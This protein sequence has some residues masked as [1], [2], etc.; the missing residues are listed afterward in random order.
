MGD[1]GVDGLVVVVTDVADLIVV[2]EKVVVLEV[3]DV[4]AIVV[5]DLM[6]KVVEEY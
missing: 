2:E 1:M 4:V 3:V 6:V 5:M